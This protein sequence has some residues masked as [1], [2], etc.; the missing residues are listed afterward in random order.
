MEELLIRGI[1]PAYKTL[2][3]GVIY[4]GN[5]S[6]LTPDGSP[7]LA[8]CDVVVPVAQ[9]LTIQDGVEVCFESGC[10]IVANGTL[11]ASGELGNP[12]KLLS[13][14]DF[15]R[16]MKLLGDYGLKNGAEFKPGP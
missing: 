4:D 12:T 10:K 11:Q 9:T 3:C 7:Y 14:H 5:G 13:E 16:G 2:I 15:N 6:P 8:T 1:R